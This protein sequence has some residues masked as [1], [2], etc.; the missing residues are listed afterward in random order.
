MFR[1]VSYRWHPWNGKNVVVI[2][3]VTK[4]GQ[5][6]VHCRLENGEV[7]LAIPL[8]MFDGPRCS[9]FHVSDNPHVH[10]NRLR[11]LE[12]LLRDAATHQLENEHSAFDP[13]GKTYGRAE[14]VSRTGP[15]EPVSTASHAATLVPHTD[16]D[17]GSSLSTTCAD[18]VRESRRSRASIAAE[19]AQS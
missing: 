4:S 3:E 16:G 6:F 7:S 8:W 17:T 1:E 9:S 12:T 14:G 13:G 15:I 10:W 2:R 11:D 18:A 19:G 5:S